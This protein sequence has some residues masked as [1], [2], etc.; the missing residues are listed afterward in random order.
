MGAKGDGLE[1]GLGLW[2]A[3][4]FEGT[5]L[6]VIHGVNICIFNCGYFHRTV[7]GSGLPSHRCTPATTCPTRIETSLIGIQKRIDKDYN[8]QNR[9]LLH[10]QI[11][12]FSVLL[13]F[14]INFLELISKELGILEYVINLIVTTAKV[15]SKY[16]P[17]PFPNATSNS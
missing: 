10:K 14:V 16:F 12:H 11:R 6:D 15:V 1:M 4:R 7:N 17:C 5:V 8:E 3:D 2:I 9:Q 13:Q